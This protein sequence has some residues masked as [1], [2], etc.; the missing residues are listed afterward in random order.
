MWNVGQVV[1]SQE[2]SIAGGDEEVAPSRGAD[3]TGAAFGSTN[4]RRILERKVFDDPCSP[5]TANSG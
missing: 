5:D 3:L 4:A 2:V 1:E